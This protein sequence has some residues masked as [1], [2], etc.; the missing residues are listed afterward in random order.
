MT[1][2]VMD[3]KEVNKEPK[4][5]APKRRRPLADFRPFLEVDV[6]SGKVL[7]DRRSD[8]CPWFIK[9]ADR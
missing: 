5:L 1:V 4:I 7:L 8:F 3:K 2:L 9:A 6:R